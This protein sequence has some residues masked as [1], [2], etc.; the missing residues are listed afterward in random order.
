MKGHQVHFRERLAASL[1]GCVLQQRLG[2]N[3]GSH[4]GNLT[5]AENLGSAHV[6][7]HAKR[8]A[9]VVLRS[10]C[11]LS[12]KKAGKRVEGSVGETPKYR[13]RRVRNNIET[14]GGCSD[15]I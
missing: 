13:E 12:L 14:S 3:S 6:P 2:V 5:S 11:Q 9:G 8:T 1:E 4:R 10:S 15:L 7:F